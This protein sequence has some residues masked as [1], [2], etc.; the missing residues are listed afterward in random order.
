MP[1]YSF[2]QIN[3]YLQCPLKYRY[4]YID[5]IPRGDESPSPHLLL[6]SA[7]HYALEMLYKKLNQYQKPSVDDIVRIFES[8][9]EENKS[10]EIQFPDHSP[11]EVFLTRGRMYLMAY[12]NKHT[13]FDDVKVVMTEGNIVFS[14]DNDE[15]LKFR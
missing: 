6:G 12:W 9:R 13:P 3:T 8:Y 15:T 11:E 5:K 10:S 4:Q 14:L 7:V 1:V 2:S